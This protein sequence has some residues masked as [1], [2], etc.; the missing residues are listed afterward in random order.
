MAEIRAVELTVIA[1]LMASLPVA[2]LGQGSAPVMVPDLTLPAFAQEKISV[3]D[4]AHPEYDEVGYQFGPYIL[5]PTISAA[6]SVDSNILGS[7]SFE[8]SDFI[9]TIK[10]TI[11]LDSDWASDAVG[12]YAEGDVA[13]YARYTSENVGNLIVRGDGRWDVDRGQTLTI[14][15]GYQVQHEDR[16]SPESQAAVSQ[17]GGGTYAK[18]PTEYS[19]TNGG[20]TYVY[21]PSRLGFEVQATVNKY[22]YTNE[23]T[24]NGGLAIEN[25]RSRVE[26][27]I[28]PRVSY[29]LIPGY[30]AFVEGWA[31]RH[32]YDSTFDATPEHLK[33]SSTG[34]AV[35]TGTQI[36][37]GDLL[38]GEVYVGYQ[39]QDYDDRRLSANS[40]VYLGASVLWNVTALT[41]LRFTASRSVQETILVGSSGFWDT[42]LNA[43]V[44]H[45]LLRNIILTA[46]VSYGIN[47][48][49]GIARDDSTISGNFGGRWKLTQIYSIGLSGVIQHRSSNLD[50][51]SFTRAIVAVDFK[52]AF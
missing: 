13:Q 17:A 15:A 42:E 32:E 1:A 35:A 48:Y 40:G 44:E 33:R 20:L 31:N 46:G 3:V 6:E 18:Y 24:L 14:N 11:S 52:A 37:L 47:E 10:P 30:Q 2:A 36:N 8:R 50:G 41:S 7:S 43:T 27:A 16:Y 23:P 26:Y 22:D 28:T 19:L 25:D 9:T 29:E 39:N 5:K 21:S 12:F 38:S 45:E 4:R 51:N 34:Y 49:Q